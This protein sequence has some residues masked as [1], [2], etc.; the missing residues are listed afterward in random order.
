MR[1]V[2]VGEE[3]GMA[4]GSG[5]LGT[6]QQ[7]MDSSDEEVEGQEGGGK[8]SRIRESLNPLVRT[9]AQVWVVA[10]SVWCVNVCM[11]CKPQTVGMTF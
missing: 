3:M 6:D 9:G 8:I 5:A 7:L 11:G 1:D 4:A 2:N 10:K